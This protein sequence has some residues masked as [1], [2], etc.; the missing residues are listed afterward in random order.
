[1]T[2]NLFWGSNSWALLFVTTPTFI[3][4]LIAKFYSCI[5]IVSDKQLAVEQ[6]I[7]IIVDKID[8]D[9][10]GVGDNVD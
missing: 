3:T 8:T 10:D 7:S 6:T 9:C 4:D 2:S 5:G 1:V